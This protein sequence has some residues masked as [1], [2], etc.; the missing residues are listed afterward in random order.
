[1]NPQRT[2]PRRLVGLVL[3]G[4]LMISGWAQEPAPAGGE[5]D[6]TL[7]EFSRDLTKDQGRGWWDRAW[8]FRRQ[9]VIEDPRL[10]AA[11]TS[12]FALEQPDPLLIYNAGA[13]LPGLRD[14]RV[15]TPDGKL[16]PAGVTNFGQDDGT[17]LIWCQLPTTRLRLPVILYLYYGNP[18]AAAGPGGAEPRRLGPPLKVASVGA[19]EASGARLR[20]TPVGARFF[21]D[22]VVVEAEHCVDDTG[23]PLLKNRKLSTQKLFRIEREGEE[24]RQ[25]SGGAYL[26]PTIPWRPD[27]L[28][29][30]VTAWAAA[31]LPDAGRWFVHVRYKTSL[32]KAGTSKPIQ[33]FLPF[34]LLLGDR[35]FACGA[36]QQ[37]GALF[38]WDSFPVELP[39]GELRVGFRMTGL[40]GP[41]CVLFT[42]HADYLPDHRD[43]NGPPW[44]RFKLLDEKVEPFFINLFCVVD[45]W[46]RVSRSAGYVF[47]SGVVPT[48]TDAVQMAG[49]PA[50][51]LAAG[52]WSP[53][54][55]APD[56]S[57]PSWWAQALFYPGAEVARRRLLDDA[58]ALKG[59]RIAF[60]FASRP[61]PARV[62]REG[63]ERGG[64]QAPYTGLFVIMPTDPGLAQL[65]NRTRTFD[66]W[67][68]QRLDV[69]ASLGLQPGQGPR[70]IMVTT[71]AQAAT[72]PE[73]EAILKTCGLL[74]F[75]GIE[76]AG[77]LQRSERFVA[78]A[79]A[80][81]FQW[82]TAH[83]WYLKFD[84]TQMLALKPGAGETWTSVLE[85]FLQAEARKCYA[86][87]A[88]QWGPPDLPARLLIMGDEIGPATSADY[89]NLI[90]V[91]QGAF[92]EYLQAQGLT[93]DF[94]GQPD[95]AA[96]QAF[97]Y[98]QARP[99]S[100]SGRSLARVRAA[101]GLAVADP[102]AG[103]PEPTKD[104]AG[105]VA[106][107]V[108][109]DGEELDLSTAEE[110]RQAAERLAAG[111][112]G[113]VSLQEKRLYHWTQ[114]FRSSY[115]TRFYGLSAAEMRRVS[116]ELGRPFPPLMSPNFQAS[117]TMCGDM[118]DGALNLF[119]WARSNTTSH[120][121]HEDWINDPYRVA[122]GLR[123]LKAAGRKHGQ[124]VGALITADR[125]YRQRY[126]MG[127]ATESRSFLS[128]TYG[129]RRLIGGAWAD[130]E[131]IVRM[132][133]EVL[134]WTAR[135]EDD[136]LAAKMRPADAAILIANTS[137]LNRYYLNTSFYFHSRPLRDR[138]DIFAALLDAQVAA[139][140]VGEEEVIED[141]ALARYR[142]LY[143]ADPHVDG[144]AQAKI[145]EWVRQGGV[146][147]AS[148]AGLMRQEYDEPSPV[149][150]EVF[151]LTA[152]GAP[153]PG[154][155]GWGDADAEHITV[156][157]GGRLPAV[158]FR[159]AP[160]RP[161][162]Q[163]GGETKVL[164]QFA[165]GA[166]ALLQH[167]F[168]QGQAFLF[169]NATAA[170]TGGFG[171]EVDEP[172]WAAA[173][174]EVVAVAARVAGARPHVRL[175]Q[176][177]VLWGVQDGPAQT[178]LILASCLN[179]DL[180]ELS[181][182]VYL[183]R[184][185]T[186][187]YSGRAAQVAFEWLGDRV[188]VKLPL[189]QGDGEII[190]FKHAGHAPP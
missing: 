31:T 14:L 153:V 23:K 120:L 62:L 16:L 155:D 108:G 74:G 40:A 89:I 11:D 83:H 55:Q 20:E 154:R 128:Y 107:R 33:E 133:A 93:P 186:A 99:E 87:T 123:L 42:R 184:P 100:E 183:P 109:D 25:T 182:E 35:E 17:S 88:R 163:L 28:A 27:Q 29:G 50:N 188:R 146:L 190:V 30:P 91:L 152:R 64:D 172:P 103:Q 114:R 106:A 142:V 135:C 37:P 49:Q 117:P 127:L 131:P 21:A 170:C 145:K 124:S 167:R 6:D 85:A 75:N 80:H 86:P 174:R 150:D 156:A 4:L 68:Q 39:A 97:T 66:Q 180:A 67:A 181:A 138:Q 36:R 38:R 149:F 165:A 143:V 110:Q 63:E 177:R 95:W 179:R 54:I 51:L 34:T 53:W 78:L 116:Q 61:D 134:R 147:W 178:V 92:H 132:W 7:G 46:T 59:Q 60:Q 41:D 70:Q 122:F 115:S 22:L 65:V 94:F 130:S 73:T 113:K 8:R 129:P 144:R 3:S 176:P 185:P 112:T 187:A 12:Q 71:M 141:N 171:P 169:G 10:L 26:A 48:E 45:P 160:C 102:G 72:V 119:E 1:M 79:R 98:K 148:H 18:A 118:W 140:L 90:P 96:V 76:V 44:L 105:N 139:E 151:G 168:G 13:S 175:D 173:A 32:Y 137:E 24:K 9:V 82:D 189:A 77:P 69:V 101:K 125:G 15:L 47:R 161:A 2:R 159:A 56:S 166:P 57:V 81:G 158:T 52:Q 58:F 136:L 84:I 104:T 164:A 43:V 121:S 126:L 157:P 19:E 162:W 5:E 111:P